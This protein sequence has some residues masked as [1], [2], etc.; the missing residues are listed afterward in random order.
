MIVHDVIQGSA[1]WKRL[2]MG[3]P[4]ASCFDKIVTPKRCEPSKQAEDYRELLLAEM[5]LGEPLDGEKFPWMER[6][7]RLEAEAAAYY[8][9]QR[10]T[11]ATRIGFCTN[12]TG[13]YGASPDRLVGED[14][15]LEIKCPSPQVHIGY[16]LGSGV[17]EK[18]KP[19]L[20]GQLLVT[21][22]KWVDICAYHPRMPHVII[23]VERDEPF[24][25]ALT[26]ELA[27]FTVKLAE[28]RAELE[29]R[30]LLYVEK[31]IVVPDFGVSEQDVDDLIALQAANQRRRLL[32]ATIF[33]EFP[34]PMEHAIGDII[35]VWEGYYTP[36]VDRS[37]W[38]E[39]KRAAE[40]LKQEVDERR[41]Q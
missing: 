24:I 40:I 13:T 6:G 21:G 39:Y 17:D 32:N 22:R 20:Q 9:L 35:R 30:G 27:K 29:R 31:P 36:N 2:R 11:E 26:V 5:V 12:D 33:A 1:A 23:R 15:L 19:Q 14:G 7:N 3:L 16:L 4:T 18:Y 28:G 10:D 25:A 41:T 8:E 38:E 34:D 37:A